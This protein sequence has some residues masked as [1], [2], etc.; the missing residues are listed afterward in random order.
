MLWFGALG[1][2]GQRS[3]V[4]IYCLEH[5]LTRMLADG[6]ML[7]KALLF[8]LYTRLR[9]TTLAWQVQLGTLPHRLHKPC[10]LQKW[11]RGVCSSLKAGNLPT[12]QDHLPLK[13]NGLRWRQEQ[14][15]EDCL[16]LVT[17]P[18]FHKENPPE[19]EKKKKKKKVRKLVCKVILFIVP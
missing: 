7:D 5:S 3:S 17:I 19:E 1:S 16:T 2:A 4:E 6:L 12:Y 15:G 14:N 13:K 10:A 8:S 9:V 18:P 11:G